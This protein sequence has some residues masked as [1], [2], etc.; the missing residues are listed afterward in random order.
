M[1]RNYFKT[2]IRNLWRN[3]NFTI[4][5]VSGLAVGIAVCLIIFL[6]IQFELSFDN[7]HAKKDRIY[8]VITEQQN[9]DGARPTSGVPFPLPGA[10]HNDFPSMLSTAIYSNR[11]DQLIVP[12]ET[13]AHSF[14]KFK[15]DRGVF[16]AEPSFFKI[17][18]FPLLAGEYESLKD[19]NNALLTKATAEKYFGDWRLAIGKTIKRNN[20][21]LLKITGILADVPDNTDLQIRILGSYATLKE[22]H[23]GNADDWHS[24]AS[25]HGCYI[26]VPEGMTAA[27]MNTQLA[28]FTKKYKKEDADKGRQLVQPLSDVHFNAALG[29]YIGRRVSKE[30][31]NTLWLIAAFILLIACVNFINLST[32]QAF[33][34]A[35]EVAVRK[36]MGS[37]RQQLRFQFYSETA[38]ITL[39]AIVLSILLVLP[40]LPYISSILNLPLS[41]SFIKNPVILLFLSLTAIVVILLAGFYPALVLSRFNPVTALK[42]KV[43][44][45][46]TKGISLRRGLVVF[47]FVVAQALITG[48]IIIVKQMDYF[49]N[50]AIGFDKEA[51]VNI[52]FPD[53]STGRAKLDFLKNKL[54]SVDGVKSASFSF[55]SPADDGNWSSNFRFDHAEKETDWNANLK[56]ADADYLKTY[57]IP[58]VAGRNLNPSDTAKEFLVN[59]TLVKRLGITDPQQAINKEIVLWDDMK[60]PIVGVVKDFNAMSLREG[61]VPVLITTVKNF[62][63]TAGIK[64]DTKDI[65]GTLKNVEAIWN[66]TYPDFVYEQKFLDEKIANFYTQEN[67][68]SQ[69]FKLFAALAIFLSCLGL[70]GLASF[71]AVQK[72]KEVGIRK[73][74]GATVNNIIFLFSKEF[75]LLISIAFLVAVPLAYYFMQDW[76]Q[77]FVYRVNISWWVIA[78]A[79]LMAIVVAMITISFKAI[80][81]AIANPV[82]SLRTE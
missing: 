6:V 77:D 44:A 38:L 13:N 48:T 8:R 54:E 2:A 71:M 33:S 35:K 52:D 63:G 42:S 66:E 5:N 26:L 23:A 56:W 18:D 25:N 17:F 58:L 3:K 15:E 65:N 59:E 72:T 67:K 60:F 4:I 14:K 40:G 22:E 70:Y 45:G 55:A 73:V 31:I 76:L 49:R 68:L 61:L 1:I 32:A 79:G 19:P 29:N 27:A 75:L 82:K 74:L 41:L 36:V 53:D 16:F 9:E 64:L 39:S 62:Y 43:S 11:D 30:L 28:T 21:Q 57:S 50:Y 46:R 34:R 51:I 24:V 20:K 80:K 37:S 69:L 10:L 81:A 12:D 7:F 47:Q 78:L